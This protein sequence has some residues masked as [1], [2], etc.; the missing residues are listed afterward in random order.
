MKLLLDQNVSH[1]LVAPLRTVYP[2]TEQVALLGLGEASD[3][4][5]WELARSQQYVIVTHDADFEAM[6]ILEGGP[7]LII[8]LRCG[9]Q[10]SRAILDRLLLHRD[11]IHSAEKDPNIWCLEIY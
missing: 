9:N 5:I 11:I 2:D 7:P 10:P 1:R 6:S 3:N 8:W 4:Q